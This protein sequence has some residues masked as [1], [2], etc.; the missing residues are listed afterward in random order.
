MLSLNVEE[1][2]CLDPQ[3]RQR[4]DLFSIS[5]PHVRTQIIRDSNCTASLVLQTLHLK[6]AI[7]SYTIPRIGVKLAAVPTD[8][9]PQTY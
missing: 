6:S 4:P 2:Y 1:P 3:T 9:T 7:G 8:A 5:I